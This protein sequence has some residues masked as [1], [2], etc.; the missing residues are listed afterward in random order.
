MTAIVCEMCNSNDII[1]Q[2]G[3]YTCQNCGTKYSV[4]DATA[5]KHGVSGA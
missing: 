4:E 2:D 1:K 5:L 3:L